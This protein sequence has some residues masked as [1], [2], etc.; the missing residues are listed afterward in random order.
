[1]VGLSPIVPNK[2]HRA[3]SLTHLINNMPRTAEEAC[4]DLVDQCSTGTTSHQHF[5]PPQQPPGHDLVIDLKG[6][7]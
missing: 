6:Q 3:P 7:G 5:R 4:Y 1:M 2:Q